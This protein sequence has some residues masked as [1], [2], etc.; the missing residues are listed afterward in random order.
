MSAKTKSRLSSL[1]SSII[2]VII[3]ILLSTIVL[4]VTYNDKNTA[5]AV[6][7]Q[8]GPFSGVLWGLKKIVTLGLS[9]P[10]YYEQLNMTKNLWYRLG[11]ILNYATP[12]IM[13]GLSIAF[14]FKTGLFNIGASGQYMIGGFF[15][16]ISALIFKFPWYLSLIVGVLAGALWGFIPGL[17][18][19]V[20]NINEVITGIMTNWIGLFSILILENKIKG[21]QSL[22]ADKTRTG[23]ITNLEGVTRILP[24]VGLDE[25]FGNPN[26]NIGIF[27]AILVAIVIFIIISKTKFGFELKACGFNKESA[28]YAGINDKKN[29]ILS[30][31]IAGG[32]AAM[33]G[34]LYYLVG[35]TG[36]AVYKAEG[37]LDQTGFEGISVALIAGSNPIG[38]IFSGLF[39]AFLKTGGNQLQPVYDT[40]V[41]SVIT[42]IIIYFTAFSL[43]IKNI[44]L[45]NKNKKHMMIGT[46]IEETKPKVDIT[47][48][49]SLLNKEVK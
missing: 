31:A 33:G 14:A 6:A 42:S 19:A 8:N 27:L 41:I 39:I 32:L 17:F 46:P 29:I 12:L 1:L 10:T 21:V 37:M 15:A 34:A 47:Q 4:F 24:R 25:L 3:G 30:M 23:T 28:K 18:K 26:S 16:I 22:G 9:D 2:C 13:T 49:E 40:E 48:E 11:E 45:K 35:G 38:V 5:S 36:G 43:F 7:A 44:L 20:F